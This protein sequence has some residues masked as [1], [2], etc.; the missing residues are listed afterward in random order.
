M[1]KTGRDSSR[2]GIDSFLKSENLLFNGSFDQVLP[3]HRGNR[4]AAWIISGKGDALVKPFKE[5][6]AF[7]GD[8]WAEGHIEYRMTSPSGLLISTYSNG[9]GSFVYQNIPSY[10]LQN[11]ENSVMSAQGHFACSRNETLRLGI[12]FTV[13][14]NGRE[15]RD[16]PEIRSGANNDLTG[17]LTLENIPIPDNCLYARVAFHVESNDCSAYL[18]NVEAAALPNVVRTRPLNLPVAGIGLPRIAQRLWAGQDIT[19]IAAGD[20]ITEICSG[21]DGDNN[22]GNNYLHQF[23]SH[24][25]ALV[26]DNLTVRQFRNGNAGGQDMD[27][28]VQ[29]DGKL[30]NR[31]D[32]IVPD[33]IIF[34]C[35]RNDWRTNNDDLC[36]D[37]PQGAGMF[38]LSCLEAIVRKVRTVHPDTDLIFMMPCPRPLSDTLPEND[39]VDDE[40]WTR[41]NETLART[42]G[43]SVVYPETAFHFLVHN[44]HVAARHLWED[45]IHPY[46]PGQTLI[47]QHLI[48]VFNQAIGDVKPAYKPDVSRIPPIGPLTRVFEGIHRWRMGSPF[49]HNDFTPMD[50]TSFAAGGI[51]LD[52]IT[53]FYGMIGNKDGDYMEFTDVFHHHIYIYV[54]EFIDAGKLDLYIDGKLIDTMDCRHDHYDIFWFGAMNT[55]RFFELTPGTHTVRIVQNG[56]DRAGVWYIG[57]V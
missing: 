55:K 53:E 32:G 40:L 52:G 4:P 18:W 15:T 50:H 12:R 37:A 29:A 45:G 20:S 34:S 9:S 3:F 33:L 49:T 51:K 47:A 36:P 57:V 54:L 30:V 31:A 17:R 14:V 26:G 23:T 27:I 8:T 38:R 28:L 6:T 24:I 13:S 41:Q 48:D 42:Y 21:D 39:D 2:I 11:N 5:S 1:E 43:G 44:R 46:K 16:L 22:E 10:R 7:Q 19:V 35:G 25:Q 56:P